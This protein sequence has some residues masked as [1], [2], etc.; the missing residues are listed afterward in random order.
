[1][2][3]G[4]RLQRLAAALRAKKLVPIHTEVP[5]TFRCIFDNV[6]VVEDGGLLG[7]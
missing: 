6:V 1:M 7:V 2:Q 3:S 4:R 5:E